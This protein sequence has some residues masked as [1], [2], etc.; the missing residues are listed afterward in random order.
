MLGQT[1]F[2]EFIACEELLRVFYFV[3]LNGSGILVVIAKIKK[4]DRGRIN[5]EKK[6]QSEVRG[7][8]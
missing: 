1:F 4:E 7:Y 6:E 8:L 5:M 3:K 2:L